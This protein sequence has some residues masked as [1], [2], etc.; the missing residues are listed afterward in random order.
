MTNSITCFL[1]SKE[2]KTLKAVILHFKV[3]H[4]LTVGDVIQCK[5]DRFCRRKF[6]SFCGFKQ[7]LIRKHRILNEYDSVLSFD[8]NIK[9]QKCNE[10]QFDIPSISD[11]IPNIV[12]TIKCDNYTV[13]N[14]ADS[15]EHQCAS[16]CAKL[17]A[18]PVI[19]RSQ[20]QFFIENVTELLSNYG[21][22]F[23]TMLKS[24][25][26]GN[27]SNRNII[28]RMISL[29]ENSFQNFLSEKL[30]LRYFE[31]SRYL[32]QPFSYYVGSMSTCKNS[33]NNII[34]A[35]IYNLLQHILYLCVK[36]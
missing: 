10:Y 21:S 5:Q 15:I 23:R 2:F 11:S 19:P 13:E 7:H 33:D 27:I 35:S 20:V 17:Y 3:S 30:R 4:C 1:C 36:Y 9:V 31:N 28:V 26:E 24:E 14:I 29:F 12:E 25:N 18:N 16:F 6:E 32:I 22:L 8:N 34:L